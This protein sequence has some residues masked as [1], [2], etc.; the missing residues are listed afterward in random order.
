MPA[1]KRKARNRRNAAKSPPPDGP[2]GDR[3]EANLLALADEAGCAD[4]AAAAADPDLAQRLARLVLAHELAGTH[5]LAMKLTGRATGLL[6]RP[7]AEDGGRSS[8]E[9]LRFVGGTARLM[10]RCRAGA[11]ALHKIGYPEAAPDP[12]D[13]DD[14]RRDCKH[15]YHFAWMFSVARSEERRRV[16]GWLTEGKKLSDMPGSDDWPP[17]Y[18]P[19][20]DIEKLD[21]RLAR[22]PLHAEPGVPR[23]RLKNGNPAGDYRKAPRCGAKTR[24]KGC[25]AQPAMANGRCR[26]HGGKSTGP[27]TAAGL[28]RSQAA[29]LTHGF[30][31]A[32]IIDLR[33]RAA[34]AGRNLH[35]LARIA[36]ETF[37]AKSQRPR[38]GR[39]LEK[40]AE[41]PR[42][43]ADCAA[44]GCASKPIG[45]ASPGPFDRSTGFVPFV[46]SRCNASAR[47]TISAGHG[48]HRS[49]R[50]RAPIPAGQA[51]RQ[52]RRRAA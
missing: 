13:G 31:T 12:D 29:R 18:A 15:K 4:L 41:P 48:V 14:P 36:N 39:H 44:E 30:R 25:C 8:M 32:E 42:R 21:E 40:P 17:Y 43:E 50:P 23:G 6:D 10:E 45:T 9:T 16:L 33:S 49:N 3:A 11:L 7:E 19:D 5:S 26:F 46:T 38:S 20:P 1:A 37:A 24:A 22:A 27:R 35:R 34:R 28:R 2:L 51:A 47:D 52:K